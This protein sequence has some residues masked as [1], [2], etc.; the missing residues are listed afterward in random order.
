MRHNRWQPPRLHVYAQAFWH[1]DAYIVGNVEGLRALRRAIDAALKVGHAESAE[2]SCGDGEGYCVRV[3]RVEGAEPWPRL[4][5]P[6]T[7]E[8]AREAREGAIR[9]ER[10]EGIRNGR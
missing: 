1:E 5:V 4:A 6:Y 9:P 10:L 2:L 3:F 8:Y 7:D